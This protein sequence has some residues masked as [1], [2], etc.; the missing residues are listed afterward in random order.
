MISKEAFRL[1]VTGTAAKTGMSQEEMALDMGYGKNYISDILSPSGKVSAKFVKAFQAHFTDGSENT[2]S[3]AGQKD[4]SALI[5]SNADLAESNKSLAY[6]HS[7]LVQMLK[8]EKKHPIN[9]ELSDLVSNQKTML[10][11]L[12]S[13]IG[14]PIDVETP[15]TI[16]DDE[17]IKLLEE[18]GKEIAAAARKNREND[19]RVISKKHN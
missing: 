7:E 8:E 10:F 4:I 17:L 11:Y 12:R 1:I 3:G 16:S 14:F 5:K 2:K 19:K 15:A 18:K 13:L 6:S 9:S